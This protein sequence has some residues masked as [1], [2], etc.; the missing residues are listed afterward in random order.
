M[1]LFVI[2]SLLLLPS[3]AAFAAK[4]TLTCSEYEFLV[5]GLD[6]VKD[7][8]HQER[9]ELRMEFVESTDPECFS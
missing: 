4:H 1:R 9:D 7:M 2:L 5:E 3:S 8:N 6:K